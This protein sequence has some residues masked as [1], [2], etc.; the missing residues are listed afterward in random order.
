VTSTHLTSQTPVVQQ[1]IRPVNLQTDLAPLADLIEL[2]FASA[3]DESGRAAIREMRYLSRMG[4]GLRIL[5]RINELALGINNGYVW[6]ENGRLVGNVSIY[7][8]N[9]PATAPT[10]WIIA[11]VAVHPDYQ[12]RGIARR[13][14]YAA[15]ALIRQK[16]SQQAILQVDVDN[17]AAIPLY[18]SL[19]FVRERAFTTWARDSTL[20]LPMQE[21][22]RDIFI[23]RRRHSEWQQEFA[24]AQQVR[25]QAAGGM[26]WLKP[27][28]KSQ[29]HTPIWRQLSNWFLMSNVE[30]LIIRS[31]DAR[32]ILASLWLENGIGSSSVRLTL[33]THPDYQGLYDRA[34]LH[35][36]LRR[37]RTSPILLEHP[38]DD[39]F[40][41][42]MLAEYRFR[43]KRSVWHMRC[44][45]S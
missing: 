28:I 22:T 44:D 40:M 31:E 27:T 35:T 5:S 43:V 24:L 39:T 8:A 23:T 18:D 19:G 13:L 30:R 12:R 32:Q 20:P 3:M 10:A 33:M 6:I 25:P 1:G 45:M 21:G 9:L 41:N 38:A 42:R 14:M 15:M 16:G 26:G 34:L 36:V 17:T 11:N 7:P 29:F 37:F 2:V 4:A